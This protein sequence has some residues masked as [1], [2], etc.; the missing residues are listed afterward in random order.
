MWLLWAGAW[1]PARGHPIRAGHARA[2]QGR[3]SRP[4][5]NMRRPWPARA[6]GGVGNACCRRTGTKAQAQACGAARVAAQRLAAEA[7]QQPDVTRRTVA[8]GT[9]LDTWPAAGRKRRPLA[10]SQRDMPRGGTGGRAGV[11]GLS[12]AGF[13]RARARALCGAAAGGGQRGTGNGIYTQRQAVVW[14]LQQLSRHRSSTWRVVCRRCRR[15]QKRG[16][17]RFGAPR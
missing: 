12:S 5:G 13:V 9:P 3:T 1:T 4:R 11:R 6:G 17:G 16:E 7:R 14:R 2:R 10:P 8:E 15:P